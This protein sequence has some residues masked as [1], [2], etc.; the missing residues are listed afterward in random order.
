MTHQRAS[1]IPDF[2]RLINARHHGAGGPEGTSPGLSKWKSGNPSLSVP[3]FQISRDESL[4][5]KPIIFVR[6]RVKTHLYGNVEFQNFL[7]EDPWT[8]RSKGREREAK[9][10]EGRGEEGREEWKREGGGEGDGRQ[11]GKGERKGTGWKDEK[12]RKR[13]ERILDPSI[14]QTDRRHWST[15]VMEE[16]SNSASLGVITVEKLHN[17][18]VEEWSTPFNHANADFMQV[19]EGNC[20]D[21]VLPADGWGDVSNLCLN[22]P[23]VSSC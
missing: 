11:E 12:R 5:N 20:N 18:L 17:M 16:E 19:P 22:M 14:F 13:R 6:K 3:N 4:D 1:I 8:A 7:A 2:F 9:G 10:R 15:E 21:R 23:Q